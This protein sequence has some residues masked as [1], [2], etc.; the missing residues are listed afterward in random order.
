MS[1]R[2][3]TPSTFTVYDAQENLIG[4]VY[5][6]SLRTWYVQRRIDG[7]WVGP[8]GSFKSRAKA[9]ASLEVSA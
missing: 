6:D 8:V 2:Q 5:R 7:A 3:I 4:R 1:L 9:L